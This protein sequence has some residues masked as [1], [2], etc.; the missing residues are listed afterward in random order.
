MDGFTYS[1]ICVQ[2]KKKKKGGQA[3]SGTK[4]QSPSKEQKRTKVEEKSP[5]GA[6]PSLTKALQSM[7]IKIGF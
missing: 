4:T 7:R 6:G 5:Y 2:K 1:T 3:S